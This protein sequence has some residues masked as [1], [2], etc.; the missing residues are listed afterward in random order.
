[1][2][3]ELILVI[4]VLKEILEAPATLVPKVPLATVV[5][6]EIPVIPAQRVQPDLK[7]RKVQPD[8]LD[9]RATPALTPTPETLVPKVL[10]AQLVLKV[11]LVPQVQMVLRDL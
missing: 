7:V 4:Q 9:H 2:D 10:Q 5:L 8:A 1:L 11:T 3:T 6:R